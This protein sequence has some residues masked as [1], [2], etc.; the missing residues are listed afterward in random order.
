MD[1]VTLADIQA[2]REV[3]GAV[4]KH[5]PVVSSSAL[6]ERF[7]RPIVLKAENLQRTGSFK[8]R[9]AM[10]KLAALG[11]LA[12][13]GVTAG[14]AGNHAQAVAFAARHFGVPCDIF[15]PAG[16]PIT[17]IEACRNYGATV[18]EGGA[19]LDE[20]MA[21][22]AGVRRRTRH[23]RSA[24][25][26]T[27]RPSSP[28]RGRSVS[29]WSTTSTTWR[30]SSCRWAAAA[31][32]RRRDR[33][34]VADAPRSDR[35]RAGR[36]VRPVRRRRRRR[37][38]PVATLADGIAVKHPGAVTGPLV[39]R[40]VDEIVVVDEDAIADAM[41]HADGAGQAVRRGSRCGR[42]R[43]AAVGRLP[44]GGQRRDVR[45]AVGG[46]RRSRRRARAHPPPREPRPGAGSSI[47]A[48]IDDRPGG[49]ARFLS[50]FAAA[51]AN[52][53]EVRAPARR[54]R[55]AACARPGSTPRSRCAVPSTPPGSSTP[56]ARPGSRTSW[57]RAR[58]S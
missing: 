9:G 53:I 7:G 56:P 20:A 17:K 42:R 47:F 36:G 11:R 57:S 32:E 46:Q 34:E 29:S 21:A 51:G 25:P 15:V 28:D 58:E 52:L 12:A 45:R 41:V 1:T 19:S 4:A 24:I 48:R 55:P 38:G 37:V 5:T 22:V 31:G 23:A 35:R 2:A 14:S 18:I 50:V 39:E 40:W 16:A 8:I 26:S 44:A 13:P 10:N 6:S 43:G 27:I 30:A 54:R 49:L 3:A 33:G